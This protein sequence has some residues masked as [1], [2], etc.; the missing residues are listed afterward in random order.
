MVVSLTDT[1]GL[2]AALVWLTSLG[3]IVWSAVRRDRDA[4]VL[5]SAVML[6]SLWGT[7]LFLGAMLNMGHALMFSAAVCM[8]AAICSVV[9][10]KSAT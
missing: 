2:I 1:V 6:L 5:A 8:V 9:A 10:A 3:A 4:T 7:Y